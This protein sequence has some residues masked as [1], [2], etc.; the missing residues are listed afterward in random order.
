MELC[1]K[2]A[3]I[4]R[5][6][7]SPTVDQDSDVSL[8]AELGNKVNFLRAHTQAEE[9]YAPLVKSDLLIGRKFAS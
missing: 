4:V 3:P 1:H 8:E 7:S 9:S 2:I 6:V 5:C